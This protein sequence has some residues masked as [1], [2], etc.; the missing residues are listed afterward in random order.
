VGQFALVY[1]YRATVS[2]A[3]IQMHRDAIEVTFFYT[4]QPEGKLAMCNTTCAGSVI[5]MEQNQKGAGKIGSL[6][7]TLPLQQ[8]IVFVGPFV[9][10]EY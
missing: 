2:S 9:P 8:G 4:A 3:T 7:L 5:P 6:G 10:A 1:T